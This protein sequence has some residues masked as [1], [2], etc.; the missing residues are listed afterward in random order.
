MMSRCQG[1]AL[2][3]MSC[4]LLAAPVM[5]RTPGI[6]DTEIKIGQN[7]RFSGPASVLG[8]TSMTARR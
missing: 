4:G 5:A 3:A 7:A 8:R 2:F 1:L 6:T